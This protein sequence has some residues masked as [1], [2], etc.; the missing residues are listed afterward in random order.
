MN[1]ACF[2][3][4]DEYVSFVKFISF[5]LGLPILFIVYVPLKPD[6]SSYFIEGNGTRMT[7]PSTLYPVNLLRDLAIESIHTTHYMNIDADLFVSSSCS[8][9]LS[10]VDTIEQSIQSNLQYL[11]NE[12]NVL[13]IVSFGVDKK[14]G[15]VRCRIGGIGCKAMYSSFVVKIVDGIRFHSTRASFS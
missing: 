11:Q 13:L 12:R 9:F 5:Y 3:Q 1:I 2:I 8:S 10:S 15:S 14:G 7:F 6:R 4:L